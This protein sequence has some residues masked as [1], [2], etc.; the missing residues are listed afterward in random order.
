MSSTGCGSPD[1]IR[2]RLCVL[3]YRCLHGTAPTYLADSLRRTADVDG[4]RCLRSSVSDTLVVT[5]TNRSTH[6]DCALPVA[7]SRA[8]NGLPS[9]VRAVSS[10]SSF[11]QELKTFLCRS[12]SAGSLLALYSARLLQLHTTDIAKRECSVFTG[13]LARL[14]FPIDPWCWSLH[15]ERIKHES[16]V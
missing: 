11:R 4:R 2:F 13:Y 7:W 10:L 5:P 12:I 15:L 3:V 1:R 6:G 16:I 8:W 9:S 14:Q